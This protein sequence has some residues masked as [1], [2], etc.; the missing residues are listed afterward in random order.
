MTYEHEKKGIKVVSLNISKEK[1][2][3]KTPVNEFN[4]NERGV[5]GD[6]HAGHWHRQ[7]SLLAK[8]S[9]VKIGT[10]HNR[11]FKDGEFAENITTEGIELI[12]V[13][14]LDRFKIGDIL[15]EVTKK[16][17]KCHS[18]CEI[19]KEVGDCIMPKEGIF[20]RVLNTGEVKKGDSIE[21]RKK[22]LR[23]KIITLSD[24]ASAGVYEDKSGPI[25]MQSVAD[26]FNK[27]SWHTSIETNILPDNPEKLKD[28]IVN[29][30]DKKTEII[31]TN[32]GIG[33]VPY[34]ITPD[35]VEP[36]CDKLIPGI[37]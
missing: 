3:I 5:S 19:F 29:S 11:V 7:V 25:I 13:S 22:I 20:C 34:N 18:G 2:T 33:I 1:G 30:V 9:I 15:L 36:L 14:L 28:E 8:E 31:S 24:R 16:G 32:G 10:K 6:A 27:T 23:I 26:F 21:Y 35:G 12:N 37:M 4:I 17:K